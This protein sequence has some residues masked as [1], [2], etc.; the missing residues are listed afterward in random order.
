MNDKHLA[1]EEGVIKEYPKSSRWLKDKQVIGVGNLIL[2]SERLVFLHQV[3]LSPR[4]T[5]NI[6]KLSQTGKTNKILDFALTLHKRNFQVP[7]SSV[8]SANMGRYSL[9]PFP[10]PYL[11]IFYRGGSKQKVKTLSFMF[12]IPL[13]KGFFQ[14]EITTVKGWARAINKA[15]RYKQSITVQR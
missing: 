9:F 13:L 3:V 12:T 6:R 4:Q 11:R 5:E 14:L 1:P 2:T 7:L 8:I 10:R 15:V